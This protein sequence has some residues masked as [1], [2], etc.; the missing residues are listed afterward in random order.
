MTSAENIIEGEKIPKPPFK[1]G[2]RKG[3]G[4]EEGAENRDNSRVREGCYVE[5]I[6]NRSDSRGSLALWKCHS[7][8]H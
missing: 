8:S 2:W 7:E 6:K 3:N 5:I 1:E 4:K